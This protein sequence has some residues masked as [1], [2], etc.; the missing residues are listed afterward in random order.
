MSIDDRPMTIPS[1][2]IRH[3]LLLASPMSFLD[4]IGWR[5]TGLRNRI[6]DRICERRLGI[7]TGGVVEIDRPDSNRYATFAYSSIVRILRNLEMGAEDVFV[8]I[9]CGMGRVVCCAAQFHIAR[10]IGIDIDEALCAIARANARRLRARFA[11]IEIVNVPAQEFDYRDCTRVLLFN[12]FGEATLNLVIGAM[13]QSLKEKPRSIRIAYVN[14][15]F[16]ELLERTSGFERY[17]RWQRRPWSGL[18]FD[19]SF[20]RSGDRDG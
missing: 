14:P 11:P 20:W 15:F 3:S 16:D 7:A 19:V 4:S 18:K 13:K 2:A 1:F 6:A 12:P 10:V 8:D 17:E 5:A 9:G